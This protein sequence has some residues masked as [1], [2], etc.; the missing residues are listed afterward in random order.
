[1]GV[2]PLIAIGTCLVTSNTVEKRRFTF[3]FDVNDFE[4]RCY[5][6]F[7]SKHLDTL[8]VLKHDTKTTI[9]DFAEYVDQLDREFPSLII[10]TDNAAYD[11]GFINYY[12]AKS[13]GRKPLQYKADGQYRVITDTDSFL[14]A[15][16]PDVKDNWVTSS[17]V[18]E[19]YGLKL[20][21]SQSHFPEDDAT[22]IALVF[23][24]VIK[25]LVYGKDCP[26]NHLFSA[27]YF[28]ED[29]QEETPCSSEAV[30]PLEYPTSVTGLSGA[31]SVPSA[32][33]ASF[34]DQPSGDKKLS[35]WVYLQDGS[36]EDCLL[37]VEEIRQYTR[38][39]SVVYLDLKE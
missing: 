34:G 9:K 10:L 14:Y 38:D 36:V 5:R 12:Y 17:T 7:W 25:R 4:E 31:K 21:K 22:Y 28:R 30:K 3:E 39:S 6:E 13:L 19:K 16:A 2:H 29:R 11:I 20:T 8:E 33:R 15:L 1:M 37:T 27:K 23:E 18:A 26:A 35:V 24:C 32:L